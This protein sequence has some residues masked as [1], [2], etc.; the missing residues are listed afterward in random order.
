M[1]GKIS[2]SSSIKGSAFLLALTLCLAAF[3]LSDE[4]V[5]D[6]SDRFLE[7]AGV[8]ALEPG[9]R[10]DVKLNVKLNGEEDLF[11]M[12]VIAVLDFFNSVPEINENNVFVSP[13]IE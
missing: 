1:F 5:M 12:F 7:Y 8:G 6:E 3:Y 9:E 2:L 11:G 13:P 10:R 4:E